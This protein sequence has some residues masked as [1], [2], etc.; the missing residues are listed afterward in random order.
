MIT[1]LGLPWTFRILAIIAFVVNGAASFFIRDRNAS[2]GSVHIAFNWKLFKRV[3]FQLFEGWL[4]LSM[5]GYTILVFSIVDYC[6]SVGLSA[7]EASLV[8]ALFNMAQGIGRP[9]IGLSSDKIGRLNI[10]MLC[11]LA[12]GIICLFFWTFAATSL[13]GCIVFAILNGAVA[14]AMWAT[15]APVCAE[16]V[17]LA[18]IPSAMSLTFLVLVLP[19]TFAEVIGLSLKKSGPRAY[20]DVQVFT[21]FMY[22]GAFAF[23]WALRAWKVQ[24]LEEAH[25]NKSQREL[26]I[27][28]DG[29]VSSLPHDIQEGSQGP[30][31]HRRFP[32]A[33]GLWA[34]QRV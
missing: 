18:L 16:V 3:P 24:E 15:L 21:G 23:G 14:G 12:G 34:I 5:L 10:S 22:M 2:I 32:N 1:R 6:R 17:G 9:I 19:A 7:S 30:K 28:D 4:F 13:A 31:L 33:R 27:R 25:L 11:T 8:G 20:L 29:V 26:A